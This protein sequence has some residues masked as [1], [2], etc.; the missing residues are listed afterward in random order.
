MPK[1]KRVP[2]RFDSE[3]DDGKDLGLDLT[4]GWCV[5]CVHMYIL[6]I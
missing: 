6:F 5:L 4:G 1:N 2:W 3:L